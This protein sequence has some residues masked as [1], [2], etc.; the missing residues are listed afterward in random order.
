M[1][2]VG[3]AV[4][5]QVRDRSNFLTVKHATLPSRKID[6]VTLRTVGGAELRPFA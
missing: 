4:S 1:V 3:A 5:P 6:A 2:G